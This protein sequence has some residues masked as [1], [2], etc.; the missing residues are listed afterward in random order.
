MFSGDTFAFQLVSEHHVSM[1]RW[2][3]SPLMVSFIIGGS[4]CFLGPDSTGLWSDINVVEYD[5]L[6]DIPSGEPHPYWDK[7]VQ[8]IEF[9]Y[10]EMAINGQ[11]IAADGQVCDVSP[12]VDDYDSYRMI[13]NSLW[14]LCPPASC[15]LYM[16]RIRN[17][18]LLIPTSRGWVELFAPY[19]SPEKAAA[20]VRRT[21]YHWHADDATT[22]LIKER[23]FGYEL[24]VL[25][26]NL[27][28]GDVLQ[29]QI[30]VDLSG[31]IDTLRSRLYE[32]GDPNCAS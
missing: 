4:G 14:N 16:A 18:S 9:S 6:P 25:R 11:I 7:F 26:G 22:G 8:S 24:I 3:L 21:G 15:M 5:L 31:V 19:N 27:C 28:G 32:K 12:C 30:L 10:S 17:D 1:N 23:S 29:Y 2:C 13:G 20:M